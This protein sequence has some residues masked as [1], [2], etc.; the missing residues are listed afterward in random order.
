MSFRTWPD[1][2]RWSMMSRWMVL[3]LGVLL[4][5]PQPASGQYVGIFLDP[6]ASSCA[7]N[8]GTNPR[9]DL[10][11][12]AVL[13]GTL[14]G[15]TGAAFKIIGAPATWTPQNVL[16][17]P[18][19]LAPVSAGDPLF[20]T[21]TYPNGG[22]YVGS[23]QCMVG[24]RVELGRLVLL[25]PPTADNVHL[26]VTSLGMYG[27]QRDCPEMQH[28]DAP[29]YSSF[30][31]GGGEIVLNGPAPSSCQLAVEQRTWTNVKSLY[32]E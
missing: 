1:S 12:I 13:D 24:D 19:Q 25:G 21:P 32:R 7:A 17:V 9:I 15:V 31:V 27:P 8:V 4:A 18:D 23:P 10:H 29:R 26:Q 6:E 30:C 20:G 2:Q 22:V 5:T 16:W 3:G 11:L 28:C 14:P